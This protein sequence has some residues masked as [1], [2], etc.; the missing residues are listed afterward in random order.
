MKKTLQ[1]INSSAN[2]EKAAAAPLFFM[3]I[4][5]TSGCEYGTVPFLNWR[6]FSQMK[7]PVVFET[8]IKMGSPA[9]SNCNSQ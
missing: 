5:E 6:L 8:P 7:S 3:V 1:I 4:V 9:A 2:I